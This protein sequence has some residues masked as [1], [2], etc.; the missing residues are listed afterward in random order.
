M[1]DIGGNIGWFCFYFQDKHGLK[2]TCIDF[3]WPGE[4]RP[5]GW[6][7][8]CGG[9]IE[10]SKMIGENFNV[11]PTFEFMNITEKTAQS[12]GE[13]DVVMVL[14]LLHLYFTQ[15]KI[16]FESWLRMFKII[17]SKAKKTF[18]FETSANIL[19]RVGAGSFEDLGTKA[20]IWGKFR[21][22]EV[23]AKSDARRPMIV[24]HR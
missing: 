4:T 14:S 6:P 11:E 24:C 15:H 12:L 1:L 5:Q 18:I 13:Y 10:F 8:D 7:T 23:L 21:T 16:S 3:D 17:A 2:T 19:A 22:V 20:K 9:K